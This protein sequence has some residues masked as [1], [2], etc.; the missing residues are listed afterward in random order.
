MRQDV[1]PLPTP[2]L[3]DE[4]INR[5]LEPIRVRGSLYVD[6]DATMT[7]FE[8]ELVTRLEHPGL[9]LTAAARDEA[10]Q[11]GA[12]ILHVVRLPSNRCF[13]VEA[14]PGQILENR[15]GMFLPATSRIDIL[16][17]QQKPSARAL[18]EVEIV[19]RREG[20]ADM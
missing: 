11:C 14:E 2:S 4:V 7:R 18:A 20:M 9:V 13:P 1:T 16:D 12:I 10:L 5:W 19:Q 15:V 3:T 8:A 17:A 6:E